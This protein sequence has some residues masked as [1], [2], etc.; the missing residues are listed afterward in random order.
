MA[1]LEPV[2]INHIFGSY[3]VAALAFFCESKSFLGHFFFLHGVRLESKT[4]TGFIK[5][6]VVSFAKKKDE[7]VGEALDEAFN[8]NQ[9]NNKEG[10]E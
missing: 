2:G 8:N 1:L 4:L 5:A 10:K 3:S 7:D 6:F 9:D